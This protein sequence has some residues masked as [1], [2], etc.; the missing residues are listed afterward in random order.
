MK[1]AQLAL[2]WYVHPATAPQEWA[3]LAAQH[4]NVSFA[5]INVHNGPGRDD[6]EYY[7]GAM[8]GLRRIRALGYVH[9]DYGNR[10]VADVADDIRR[11]QRLYEVDG[12]MLDE[13]P[14]TAQSLARC[15]DYA[16]AARAE[17][18]TFLAGN[19]G[20]FP[21]LAHLNLF[22]VT[23]VFEGTAATYADFEHPAWAGRIPPSQLWHLVYDCDPG[24]TTA[25][26]LTAAKRG[27]GHVFAT[28]RSLPNPWLGPPSTVSR[29]LLSGRHAVQQ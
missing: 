3:W 6:D 23:A 2:P 29:R 8:A 26:G 24:Q 1:T 28:D 16:A 17:G 13:I 12:I 27:A 7:P 18:I 15:A 22:D 14:S 10:P 21:S 19:P 9:V 11:W 25:I 4:R 20:V 5:V